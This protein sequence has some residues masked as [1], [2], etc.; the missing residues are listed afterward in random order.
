MKRVALALLMVVMA[1]P[2]PSADVKLTADFRG[3]RVLQGSMGASGTPRNLPVVRPFAWR[4]CVGR[5]PTGGDTEPGARWASCHW[6]GFD[7]LGRVEQRMWHQ[8]GS[9]HRRAG[10]ADHRILDWC[11]QRKA[12]VFLQ[13][14]WGNMD[15]NAFPEFREPVARVHSG[16]VSWKRLGTASRAVTTWCAT[17]ATVASVARHQQRAGVRLSGGSVRPTNRA[18]G[19]A[20]RR[21]RPRP[22]EISCRSAGPTGQTCRVKPG[23]WTS[24][25]AGATTCILPLTG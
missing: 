13:V 19:E 3:L 10:D 17:R 15:W 12:D 11:E 22:P 8:A 24:T 5:E 7:F 21:R 18:L 23:G 6:L 2:A 4:Q 1:A 25:R 16:P 14:M 20:R 9:V